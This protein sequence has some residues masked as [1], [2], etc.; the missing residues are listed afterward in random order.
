MRLQITSIIAL[1]ILAIVLSLELLQLRGGL[2]TQE[3]R[4]PSEYKR[5][6][7]KRNDHLVKV[8]ERSATASPSAGQLKPQYIVAQIR[9]NPA[10]PTI[11]NLY[12]KLE[13]ESI[14]EK[15]DAMNSCLEL[16]EHSSLS[17][18]DLNLLKSLLLERLY[19]ASDA[20][21]VAEE[22]HYG[23]DVVHQSMAKAKAEVDDEIKKVV[24]ADGLK[25]LQ[26][27]FDLTLEIGEVR[28]TYAPEMAYAGEPLTGKQKLEFARALSALPSSPG[29]LL[30]GF[31]SATGLTDTNRTLL[32]SLATKLSSV[33]LTVLQDHLSNVSRNLIAAHANERR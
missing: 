7:A 20:R 4:S 15:Y 14:V 8:E 24:G 21:T 32:N 3:V 26:E 19:G 25:Q 5:E 16:F 1:L 6:V 33:Q 23:L 27:I 22:N 2:A 17:K 31:D 28:G 29:S 18:A 13:F 9:K 10:T 30:L 12:H 11:Q